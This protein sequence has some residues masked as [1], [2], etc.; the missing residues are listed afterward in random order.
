MRFSVIIPLYNK[1]EFIVRAV[2]SVLVQDWQDYELLIIDDGS[3]DHGLQRVLDRF[4]D[5]R[6]QGVVQPNAGEGAAR[7]RGLKEMRGDAAAFLDADDEWLPTHLSDL[8]TMAAKFPGAGLLAT[9]FRAVYA[10]G[11]AVDHSIDQREPSLVEDYYRLATLGH[12]VHVSAVAVDGPLL[13]KSIRFAEG[14][15]IGADEEF[16]ARAALD[17]ALAYHPRISA[18]Y[19]H[20]VAGSAMAKARCSP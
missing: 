18:I 10:D 13:M 14:A 12:P 6:I 9:G 7:N 15:S 20:D 19:H 16:Y 5:S 4:H 11:L 1:A 17:A 2:Q 8:A 3:T